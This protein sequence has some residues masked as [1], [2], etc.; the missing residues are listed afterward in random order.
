LAELAGRQ[1]GVL[2]RSQLR[3]IGWTR[4]Q[5]DHELDVGRWQRLAP[6]VLCRT[7]GPLSYRQR[8]WLGV[9][10][11]GPA[12][13][14][15]H[16]TAC[17]E[18]GLVRWPS[19]QVHVICAKSRGVARLDGF[20]FHETRRRFRDWI[21][22]DAQPPRLSVEAAALLRA[23]RERSVRVGIGVLA[24]VVQQR[25]STAERLF[26][27]SLTIRKLRHGETLRLALLDI[28]GGAQSFAELD[29]G[30]LCRD[31]ELRPPD[32][33]VVRLDRDGRRR[34][35]DCSWDLDDGSTVGLE[36]DGSFHLTTEHWWKDIRRQRS[37]MAD[38]VTIVRCSTFE[39][40]HD[41]AIV[42]RDLRALGVP[43]R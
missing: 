24:A 35:L 32:R 6:E 41:P 17:I 25:L 13:A 5:I 33:Q 14:L 21:A 31:F 7:T 8:L 27:V 38:G 34:Y 9:L 28:S 30:R 18:A 1:E 16:H 43:R 37:L 26:E 10:H 29:V 11:A 15:S 20:V 12:S 36:I 22:P 4:H 39:L 3:A 19:K 42:A 23:E 40:R 2:H